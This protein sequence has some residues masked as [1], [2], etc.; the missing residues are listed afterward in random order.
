M[1]YKTEA[2]LQKECYMWFYNKYTRVDPRYKFAYIQNEFDAF[3]RKTEKERILQ[4]SINKAMGQCKGISDCIVFMPYGVAIF[5]E[6]KN[7]SNKQSTA[8]VAFESDISS[9]GFDYHVCYT[10]DRFIDIID[11]YAQRPK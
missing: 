2:H 6:F 10:L 7:G 3:G 9:S 11:H 4:G 8:Q 5:I 1:T